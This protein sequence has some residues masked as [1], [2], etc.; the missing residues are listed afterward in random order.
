M[1]S[2]SP[3]WALIPGPAQGGY[4]QQGT[5]G[6]FS[7]YTGSDTFVTGNFGFNQRDKI[8]SFNVSASG[9]SGYS[10]WVNAALPTGE[11]K[12]SVLTGEPKAS[13]PTGATQKD[14]EEQSL[15]PSEKLFAL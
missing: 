14:K 9:Q 12:A 7:I 1:N 5:Q 4:V 13:E 8:P 10:A 11:P 6:S 2:W 3:A 15:S